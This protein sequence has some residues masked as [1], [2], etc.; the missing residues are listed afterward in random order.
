MPA[1][2][3]KAPES[4]QQDDGL[5]RPGRSSAQAGAPAHLSDQR[6][7]AALDLPQAR[8]CSQGI[9]QRASCAQRPASPAGLD[10][11]VQPT[12]GFVFLRTKRMSAGKV[13]RDSPVLI[14]ALELPPIYLETLLE[15]RLRFSATSGLNVEVGEICLDSRTG[16]PHQTDTPCGGQELLENLSGSPR[17]S[18]EEL[19]F[20]RRDESR[21]G[22]RDPNRSAGLLQSFAVAPAV[23]VETDQ[24]GLRLSQIRLELH[25]P[26][27]QG[28]GRV[29]VIHRGAHVAQDEQGCRRRRGKLDRSLAPAQRLVCL[30]LK[31]ENSCQVVHG[32]VMVGSELQGFAIGLERLAVSAFGLVCQAE[33]LVPLREPGR[34]RNRFAARLQARVEPGL[35]EADRKS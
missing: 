9:Q 25:G 14:P 13:E 12:E 31:V 19:G 33:G 6:L 10:R 3:D 21:V 29:R 15:K 24:R 23:K 4:L 22:G 8:V 5:L 2:S 16:K 20:A 32:R 30:P 7:E 11:A 17:V 34:E 27:D 18:R 1:V 35:G 28:L 26:A